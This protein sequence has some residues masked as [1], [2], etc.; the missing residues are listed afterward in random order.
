[1]AARANAQ[2]A[3][4]K[5]HFSA[6]SYG[7]GDQ[8]GQG[9][10]M[11][12]IMGT[13]AALLCCPAMAGDYP[14]FLK[15]FPKSGDIQGT[16]M[17]GHCA[18]VDYSQEP[19]R[20]IRCSLSQISFEKED[21]KSLE[22]LRDFMTGDLE[23]VAPNSDFCTSFREELETIEQTPEKIGRLNAEEKAVLLGPR[24]LCNAKTDKERRAALERWIEANERLYSKSC[25]VFVYPFS[26]VFALDPRADLWVHEE[27]PPASSCGLRNIYTL[28]PVTD[29]AFLWILTLQ[30]VV[31]NPEATSLLGIRCSEMDTSPMVWAWDGEAVRKHCDVIR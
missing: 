21:P 11:K 12:T 10:W 28:R 27:H 1:M 13:V 26:A 31:T 2:E 18:P 4:L 20:E 3:L 30:R 8:A 25:K 16:I 17:L 9:G 5:S 14:T 7:E 24:S 19:I 6:C 15:L 23:D 22:S 29:S